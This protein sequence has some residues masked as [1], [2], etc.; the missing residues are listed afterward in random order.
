MRIKHTKKVVGYHLDAASMRLIRLVEAR[1]YAD[2][3]RVARE[4][5]ANFAGHPLALRALTFALTGLRRFDE[6]VP[7]ADFALRLLPEDGE[8][9]NNRAIALAELMRWDEAIP[10]F[11]AS[12]L[13]LPGDCEIH[14]NLGLAY[15]RLHRWEESIASLLKAVELHPDDYV[16]AIEHLAWAL[17]NARRYDEA[18][19]VCGSLWGSFPD[20]LASLNRVVSVA[21]H[22]CDWTGLD[23]K[24][25]QLSPWFSS[26]D[27]ATNPWWL[28]KY[29]RTSMAEYRQIAQQFAVSMIPENVRLRQ[30]VLPIA[31]R[32]GRRKLRVGYMSS[33]LADHPVGFVIAELIERHDRDKLEI[34]AYSTGDDDG[35]EHRKRLIKNFDHFADIAR[36]S[37][38]ATAE[39]IRSDGIDVLVDLNG[40]TGTYRAES[41]AL[42]CAPVQVSWLGYAGTMGL[43]CFADYVVGDPVVTPMDQQPW[44]TERIV[45]MP[46]S[47][48]PVDT[49]HP[50]AAVPSRQSQ[51]LSEDAFV[52]CSFNNNYKFNPP[53]FDLWCSFL[54][55][56]PSAV[57]WLS[58]SNDTVM[59]NLRKEVEQRGVAPE[60]L[61]FAPRVAARA[62]HLARLQLADLSLD[63][64]PY[65]SHST[66]G[67][68]LI[69]G[70]PMVTKRGD[71]FPGLVGASMMQAAGLPEL[72]AD[73][74]AGYAELILDLYHDRARL[75]GLKQKLVAARDT[76]PLFDMARFARDLEA[77]YF[78]MAAAAPGH[79]AEIGAECP[80]VPAMGA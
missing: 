19:V 55:Q 10:E 41:L 46:H 34:F 14:Q 75:A 49:R 72:I 29:W 12:L 25:R 15:F 3:E 13:L 48:M 36:L 53:L 24:L 21:L 39:R 45:Q 68:A 33:D 11:K 32:Q 20:D 64:F 4:L 18:A 63:T 43:P 42:R 47:Y 30:D 56:M 37:A 22:R 16:E 26:P 52:L 62:D 17:I 59:S 51:G 79:A 40:W 27:C 7:A 58:K 73:D 78:T 66:G 31:W 38:R 70:V 28:F 69:V 50:I 67:D 77:L 5:L 2:V 44:F 6:V 80:Q 74:D 65:N 54:K 60:R 1:R 23:E 8:I 35:G 57:L 71:T 9:R 61:V 76:A